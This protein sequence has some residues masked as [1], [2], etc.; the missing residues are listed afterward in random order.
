MQPKIYLHDLCFEL[1]YL[2]LIIF[3]GQMRTDEDNEVFEYYVAATDD[4]V[5]EAAAAATEG[6]LLLSH[7][8]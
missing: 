6:L 1:F 7:S 2:H 5:F 8:V 4:E 3:L